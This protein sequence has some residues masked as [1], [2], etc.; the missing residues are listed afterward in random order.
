MSFP[1]NEKLPNGVYHL[2]E[3]VVNLDQARRQAKNFRVSQKKEIARLVA[4]GV[5]HLLGY[6]DKKEKA[7]RR[8]KRLEDRI[9]YATTS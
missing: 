1:F 7:R 5:L 3:V 6:D 9:V 8:M 4:H 2:G